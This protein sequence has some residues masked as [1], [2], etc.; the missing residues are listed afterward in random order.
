MKKVIMMLAM[1]LATTATM[2]A[3]QGEQG[4]FTVQPKVGMNL[5]TLSDADKAIFD[6]NFGMEAEYMLTDNVG[7]AA[8]I[9][10]SN[11]GGKYDSDEEGK[12]TADLDYLNIPVVANFYVLPGLALKAGIQPGYR[13]KAKAKMDGGTKD[14]DDLYKDA[15]L[16]TDEE[17]KISKIDLSIPV[18][19]SYEYKNLVI[20]ARYNWGLIKIV[21]VEDAFY[22][23]VFQITLGYKL[24]FDI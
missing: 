2:Q 14:L 12:Y 11:Q 15:S 20:D 23:R 16:L 7:M 8:G 4:T 13:T 22:N 6:V 5:S 10:M 9:I 19:I 21:N 3:Q 17:I 18:G 24:N 1:M